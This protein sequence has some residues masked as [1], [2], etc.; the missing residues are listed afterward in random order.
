MKGQKTKKSQHNTEEQTWGTHATLFQD[1]KATVTK[2]YNMVQQ[3]TQISG[4]K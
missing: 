3:Q 1:Y 2:Q 4:T